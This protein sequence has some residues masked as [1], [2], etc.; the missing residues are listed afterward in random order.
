V[1]LLHNLYIHSI[2][3]C[4]VSEAFIDA[5]SSPLLNQYL[6]VFSYYSYYSF[7]VPGSVDIC[8]C[9]AHN[10]SMIL[11]I[12]VGGAEEAFKLIPWFFL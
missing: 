2:L 8:T 1:G 3:I 4:N 6:S 5:T 11:M 9:T 12:D 10:I 7:V